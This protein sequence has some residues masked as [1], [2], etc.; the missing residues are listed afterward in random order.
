MIFRWAHQRRVKR[1][2]HFQ[3][4]DALRAALLARLTGARHGIGVAGDHRLIG[5]VDVGSDC[6][7]GLL[8]RLLTCR[9]DLFR[10]KPEDG[11]HRAGSLFAR[12][13]HQLAAPAHELRRR[14]RVQ[15]AGRHVCR[16]L[17][18]RMS[19]CGHRGPPRPE[20]G[21]DDRKDGGAVRENRRLCVLRRDEVLFGAGEHDPGQA[22]AERGID[23]VEDGAC[24]WKP[25]REIFSHADFLR[26]LPRAEPDRAYH[27]T[28]RLPHVKPAP[29]AHSITTMPGFN[30]PVLTASSSAIAIDAAEVLPKRSTFT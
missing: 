21:A 20:F 22:H 8:R 17:T 13:L 18:E 28:T 12:L 6:D 27:R 26:A 29:N 19:G 5:S 7:A 30:R 11:R 25:F 1:P 23:R 3:R 4:N 16:V 24:V 15:R 14:R 10:R 9:L 2:A